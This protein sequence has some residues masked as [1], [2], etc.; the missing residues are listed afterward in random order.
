MKLITHFDD[1]IATVVNLNQTRLDTLEKRVTTISEFLRKSDYKPRI[2]RFSP[3][4]SYAHKTIIKPPGT[5][6]YDADL[7]VI[8]DR[9]DGWSAADY[10]EK[11]YS[12]FRT[13]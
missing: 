8:I 3:Q 2:R 11:L 10:V 7:L 12:V 13:S 9:V 5:R 1:F 6:D 4:G